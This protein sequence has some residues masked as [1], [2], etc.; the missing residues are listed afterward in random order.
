MTAQLPIVR[1]LYEE[2][3]DD[4]DDLR[5]QAAQTIEEL[6]RVVCEGSTAQPWNGKEDADPLFIFESDLEPTGQLAEDHGWEA[7]I[8]GD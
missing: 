3:Q 8:D 7:V 1:R 2:A 4:P 5:Y 6:H